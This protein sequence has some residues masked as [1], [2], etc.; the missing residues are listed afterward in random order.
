M[1]MI[2]IYEAKF[3]KDSNFINLAIE[4]YIYKKASFII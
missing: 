1:K 3:L 4:I 2:F